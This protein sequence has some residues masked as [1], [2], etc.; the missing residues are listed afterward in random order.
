MP[1]L[2]N[3]LD[4]LI[5]FLRSAS[6]TLLVIAALLATAAWAARTRRVS[7]FSALGRWSRRWIDPLLAP[8]DRRLARSGVPAATVPWWALLGV[9]VGGA[10]AIFVV[11]F[12]RDAVVGTYVATNAGPRGIF[13]LA[14]RWSFGVLQ[15]ALLVRIITS[16]IGGAYSA[17]GRLSFRL[18]EWFLGPLRRALP[19]LGPVDIS[20]MVAWLGL[21]MVERILMSFL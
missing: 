11:S 21:L 10:A 3:W 17:V 2:I 8:L 20:P 14:V 4:S 18:T 9:L 12:V 13:V 16:W 1:S 7:P 6:I 19:T 15:L 5:A